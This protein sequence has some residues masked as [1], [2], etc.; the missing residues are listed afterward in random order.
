MKYILASASPRRKELLE[1]AG[2]QFE[3]I[4]SSIEEK[5]SKTLAPYEL[6]ME[7]ALEKANDV[8]C[9]HVQKDCVV[10][11]ADTIVVYRDEILGK[12]ADKAE[13]YDM[14]SMLADRTH[15]VYTGVALVISKKG[16]VHTNTFYESTDVT[17]CPISREDLHAYI[18]TG[19]PLDKAGAYG[20]QGSF[21]IHVKCIHGDYNNVVGLPVSRL[22]QELLTEYASPLSE[23]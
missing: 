8:F 10:I 19:D 20:I 3:V 11:G 21:A 23:P 5:I 14:L 12:P 15:Q 6:V 17:F 2:F 16:R 22:Y 7:L 4:P 1:L 13:A 18:E 9:K